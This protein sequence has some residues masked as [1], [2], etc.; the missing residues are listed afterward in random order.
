[1]PLHPDKGVFGP[2][3]PRP[4]NRPGDDH[5]A[6]PPPETGATAP[7]EARLMPDVNTTELLVDFTAEEPAFLRAEARA[8]GYDGDL[9]RFIVDRLLNRVCLPEGRT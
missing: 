6:A 7:Q 8:A 3:D 9:E 1:M 2:L 4:G 5:R